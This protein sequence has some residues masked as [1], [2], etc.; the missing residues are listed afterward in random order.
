MPVY[1]SIV[2]WIER[3]TSALAVISTDHGLI[4]AGLAF[5]HSEI[6]TVDASYAVSFKTP[7]TSYVHWKPTGIAAAGGPLTV[8]LFEGT[9]STGGTVKTPINKNRL[10]SLTHISD[11]TVKSGVTRVG[12][13][14]VD[15]LLIPSSTNGSQ[16]FGASSDAE[17]EDV[18]KQDTEYT[19]VFTES[20]TG[21]VSVNLRAFWY[22]E[23]DA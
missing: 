10:R 20:I 9:T 17:E 4:H 12:G 8:E 14:V 7:A 21:T 18:L 5:K 1:K 22:E 11:T 6:F 2:A 3:V 13:T 15:M 19:M 16:K 23:G